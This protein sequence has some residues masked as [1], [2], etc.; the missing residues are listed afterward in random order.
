M[1]SKLI[2]FCG[3]ILALFLSGCGF[4]LTEYLLNKKTESLLSGQIGID[5]NSEVTKIVDIDNEAQF[6]SNEELKQVLNNMNAKEEYPHEPIEGQMTMEEAITKGKEWIETLF[7]K[8]SV[9][10]NYMQQTYQNIDAKLCVKNYNNDMS[11]NLLNSYWTLNFIKQNLKVNLVLNSVTGQVLDANI[12]Y[13]APINS[14]EDNC[15]VTVSSE[16]LTILLTDYT[17]SFGF[18]CENIMFFGKNSIYADVSGDGLFAVAVSGNMGVLE[19][20]LKT[21]QQ[22]IISEEQAYNFEYIHLYF[23]TENP[24]NVLYENVKP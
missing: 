18:K 4:I 6:L 15:V 21:E 12:S 24:Q 8:N 20:S 11:I 1:K 10:S 5:K 22:Y 17:L 14:S 19:K 7:E 3:L 9:F 2:N 23:T 16:F 13:Y